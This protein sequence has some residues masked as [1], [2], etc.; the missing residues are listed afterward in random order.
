MVPSASAQ[1]DGGLVGTCQG[2][3]Q[4]AQ[5]LRKSND[6]LAFIG[7]RDVSERTYETMNKVFIA[8]KMKPLPLGVDPESYG[9]RFLL[10]EATCLREPSLSFREAVAKLYISMRLAVGLSIEV[11]K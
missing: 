4:A 5:I 1:D 2:F 9:K 6:P 8:K 10:L 11:P 7:Y 3:L